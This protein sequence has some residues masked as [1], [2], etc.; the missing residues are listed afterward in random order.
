MSKKKR[1]IQAVL[2]FSV[3]MEIAKKIDKLSAKFEN[4]SQ[5]IKYL[6]CKALELEENK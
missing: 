3:P 2:T 6:V 4:R 1:Q 5:C